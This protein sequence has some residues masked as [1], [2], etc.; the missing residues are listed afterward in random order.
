MP[1]ALSVEP[2][3]RSLSVA[4]DQTLLD[5]L[6]EAGI[7]IQADC[8]GEGLCGHCSVLLTAG[9]VEPLDTSRWDERPGEGG[10][11]VLACQARLLSDATIRLPARAL[12][13]AMA[14]TGVIA[15]GEHVAAFDGGCDMPLVQ[16]RAVI[17]SAPTVDDSTADWQRLEAA[18]TEACPDTPPLR[19]GVEVFQELPV[20]LREG[21]F[22]IEAIL[23]DYGPFR[24]VLDLAAP[25]ADDAPELG[26]AVDVGTSTVVAQVVDL[27]TG[28]LLGQSAGTNVQKRYGAD[29]ITRI[30]WAEETPDGPAA[31]QRLIV[32]QIADL[33]ADACTRSN[34]EP[35]GIIAASLS[36][37]ATMA[38]FLL[39][40]YPGTIRRE[41]HVPLARDLPTFHAGE[42]GL[43]FHPRAPV[44]LAPAV[45]GFVGGDIASGVLA[46]GMAHADELSLLVDV[47][48]NGEI[49]LGNKDWLICCSCSA[50]PAFE[51][52]DIAA[53]IHAVPG[54][55]DRIEYD[56]AAD[57]FVWQTIGD[58][59]PIGLCGTGLLEALAAMLRGRLIDRQGHIVRL[60]ETKLIRD[61][62]D[63]R[64]IIIVPQSQSGTGADIV[65]RHSELDNLI[66]SKAAVYAGISCLLEAVQ[67]Q[68]EDIQRVYIAG[69]FGNRLR[70][71]EAVAIGML[72]D[73]SRERI[74]FVGNTS[75]AGAYQT[76]VS[77]Q[78]RGRISEIARRMTYLELSNLPNFMEEFVRALFLPHTELERFPS[79]RGVAAQ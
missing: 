79:Q 10:R 59:P 20:L 67:V 77:R 26:I 40:A 74:S 4:A 16:R 32:G 13:G 46:T 36:G 44:F 63:E 37:N 73:V 18:L 2:L 78:A 9:E 27:H 70:V 25:G 8:G 6:R 57:A 71:E 76:L 23:A 14:A 49:V 61:G 43:P 45:S 41:P 54:A 3:G 50:G 42:L 38:T 33:V 68:A 7:E 65:L 1:Y 52:V 17:V 31:M 11:W 15:G 39:G 19:G 64:E 30:I 48:T 51:G 22:H 28:H 58:Q 60:T 55:I 21:R 66:R 12:A 29:V 53:G 5:A 69:S 34:C 72:P 24:E 75:L 35:K 62:D 56:A 47:G